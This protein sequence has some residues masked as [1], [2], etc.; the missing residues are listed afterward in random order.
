MSS[1]ALWYASRGSGV[2]SLVLLT[3]VLVLGVLTRGG[4]PLPGLPRFA[5]AGLHRNAALLSVVF[6]LAHIGTAILD[7]YVNLSWTAALVPFVAGYQPFRTGLGAIALDLIL[8]LVATSL[9]RDRI[10]ARTWKALHW[11]A[12]LVWPVALL[13]GFT[14]GTDLRHGGLLWLTV[15]C[16]LLVVSS[17]AWRVAALSSD[18]LAVA[19][20]PMRER[21]SR[22]ANRATVGRS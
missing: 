3:L 17:V 20:P 22:G 12:Y 21:G 7:S 14:S 9:L 1:Q 2:V 16:V 8:A 15:G 18:R 10:G 11:T 6:L 4:R 13:H 5:V 19:Q